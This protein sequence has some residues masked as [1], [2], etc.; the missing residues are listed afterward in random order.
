MRF[1]SYSVALTK[2]NQKRVQQPISNEFFTS[3]R[4]RFLRVQQPIWTSCLTSWEKSGSAT[5]WERR[6]YELPNP[7]SNDSVT[8]AIVRLWEIGFSNR[9]DNKV[10]QT[11][12]AACGLPKPIFVVEMSRRIKRR[13]MFRASWPIEKRK[14]L[15]TVPKRLSQRVHVVCAVLAGR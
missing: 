7:I 13:G 11:N 2:Q 3:C 14:R 6:V 9:C 8:C 5:N 4:T 1:H 10:Q 12:W 15:F